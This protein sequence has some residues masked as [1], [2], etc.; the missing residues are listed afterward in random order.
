MPT[1]I[2]KRRTRSVILWSRKTK[3]ACAA[4]S[5]NF[6]SQAEFP[7]H[8]SPDAPGSIHEGGELG[9]SLSHAFGAA[10][11]NP[12]LLVCAVVGDGE[13]E[14]GPLAASWHGNKFLN[15]HRDGAVLPI[16][17]LNGYKISG[18]TVLARI[19]D[20]ELV[21]LFRGYGYEP[22][23]VEG[24]EPMVVHA[25]LATALEAAVA[26]I[27]SIQGDARSR[28]VTR[29]PRWPMIVLRTP[30]GWTGPKVVDGLPV[31]GTFR[32]HQLPII[33]FQNKPEH[34]A[35]LEAWMRSY[36]PAELF[37]ENGRLVEGMARLAPVGSRR[38]SMNPHANG[39]E[40]LRE[41]VMPDFRAYAVPVAEAGAADAAATAE[42]GK[43]LRDVM[44]ANP[45][46]FRVFAPDETASNRL[47]ALF[48]VTDRCS[49]ARTIPTDD[50]VSAGGRVM[51]ILSEH[52]CQGW[53]EGY[54]LTGRHAVF[55]SYEAFVHIV[56]SMFNQHAKWLE[57][58]RKIAWRRPIA[59]LNYLIT[60][61]VWR[62]DNNGFTH[63]DPGFL[64]VVANKTADVVRI[65][66]PPDANTLLSVMDHC[67]RSKNYVNVVVAGKHPEMQWLDIDAAIAHCGEGIGI[68][69]WASSDAGQDPT[70]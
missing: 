60:S 13:A 2:W 58:S 41:L 57:V 33:G 28:G 54:L 15:P 9:Y 49:T 23:V 45:E 59:S 24:D 16:L 6:R 17:H 51:E 47:D 21:A 10:F 48:E 53:A 5:A 29:R 46:N 56:D 63:Q 55:S 36:R 43:L 69:P 32:A 65:Y 37:D 40:L 27:A 67:L 20:D 22:L 3:P 42:A 44:V 39:G 1:P 7:S 68:W 70:S 34:I 11:D 25:L 61:H 38:M 4:Y 52:T 64:D 12:G 35:Q 18:P 19:D 26:R 66:L 62:Q 30:K 50:H 8:A 14:T 31:E